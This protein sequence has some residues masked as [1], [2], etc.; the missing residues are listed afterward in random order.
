MIDD[1]YHYK[2]FSN[3]I[4]PIY[5]QYIYKHI[6]L[7]TFMQL[8]LPKIIP[9]QYYR[10]YFC[11]FNSQFCFKQHAKLAFVANKESWIY[12]RREF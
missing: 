9:L 1:D 12:S 10:N 11:S 5:F 8:L 3:Y 7:Y 4:S 6:I 2:V